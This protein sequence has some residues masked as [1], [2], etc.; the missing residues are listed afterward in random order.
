MS[1]PFLA[2]QFFSYEKDLFHL[3]FPKDC[4]IHF[5]QRRKQM[6]ALSDPTPLCFS[7]EGKASLEFLK[8]MSLILFYAPETSVLPNAEESVKV[9]KKPEDQGRSA[10][11][12]VLWVKLSAITR[13]EARSYPQRTI[14]SELW[15]SQTCLVEWPFPINS[16]SPV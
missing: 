7:L 9:R 15:P 1:S 11:F 2:S 4:I 13:E 8:I 5:P 14:T 12:L 3:V 16:Q 6:L 10:G